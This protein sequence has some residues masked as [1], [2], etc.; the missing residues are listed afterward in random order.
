M[1]FSTY[2]LGTSFIQ[3][4]VKQMFHAVI[5]LIISKRSLTT[6]YNDML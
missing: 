6:N 2:T 1:K 5:A 4:P 3:N